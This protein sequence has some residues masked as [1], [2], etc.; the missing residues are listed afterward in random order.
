MSQAR[1]WGTLTA[2][3]SA[4][5]LLTSLPLIV[6]LK[7][8][9]CSLNPPSSLQ[10]LCLAH[11]GLLLPVAPCSS[12][13]HCIQ[14]LL[15]CPVK[16]WICTTRHPLNNGLAQL[17]RVLSAGSLPGSAANQRCPQLQRGSPTQG[18]ALPREIHRQGLMEG[19][20]KDLAISTVRQR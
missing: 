14:S 8:L 19:R 9:F 12:P 10:T 5:S 13:P 15:K 3:G 16:G 17:G 11:A 7:T 18:H 2:P 20:I 1:G 6:T 4:A